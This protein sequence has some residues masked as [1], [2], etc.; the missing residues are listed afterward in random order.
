MTHDTAH[1]EHDAPSGI[2]RWLFT[3][4]HKDIGILYLLFGLT[5]FFVGGLFAEGIRTQ[6]L[7]PGNH[8]LPPLV[9]NQVITLHGLVMVFAAIMPVSTGFANYLIPMQIGAPDMALPRLNNLGFWL[10]PAAAVVLVLPLI[11]QFVGIGSGAI[12]T[13][14]T[15]YAPLSLQSG[16]GVDFAIFSVVLLGASSLLGSIN[17][18]VTI[19]NLRAP[20]MGLMK[21][22][23]FVWSWFMTSIL[24]IAVFPALLAGGVMLLG[25]RHFGTHFF[26]AA[27][28]GDP[29]LWQHLF[30]FF[31]HPEVYILLF[32]TAGIMSHMIPTFAR[33][34]LFG[35]TAQV[36]SYW[37][38]GVLS[39]IVWAHHM[40]TSG[41][42]VG[43]QLYFMYSTMA[44]SV[45]LSVLFF[46]W[47]A[48]LWRGSISY[49]TPMLFALGYIVLFAFGG[50]T[51]LVL[52]DSVAD[53][54]YHNSYFLVAHFHYALF[55]GPIMGVIAA[56]YY[57]LPKI[58]GHMY[59]EAVGKVHFW[60]TFIGFN[61]TFM[62]QF[63]LGAAGMPRRIPDYALQFADLN[64]L[65]SYGAF[66]LGAA[67]V[68]M[69]YNIIYSAKGKG[70]KVSAQVWEGAEGLEF[71]LSSPPPY[72]SFTQRPVID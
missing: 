41:M 17:I 11:L 43:A 47:L 33:K 3:T 22:P 35:Y 56:G 21:M 20:G 44:I 27:G 45:P 37:V 58:T 51:G 30:W 1:A 25:D 38:I 23:M 60:L 12:D 2:S 39:V 32:P 24:L 53:Q 26:I 18:I 15:I 10:L 72:H 71:T 14:W 7:H 62:P 64:R 42:P 46:C 19:L 50:L 6:L 69:V 55:G 68:L 5:M 16:M 8:F 29:V 57:W 49:E 13:G 54:Q 9:Y 66:L 40:F 67:Q 52:A 48:T 36:Y 31:G 28:G 61:C 59:N 70:A 4:N 34:P 63:L 65:S